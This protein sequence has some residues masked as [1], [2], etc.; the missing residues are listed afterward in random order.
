M[1][2]HGRHIEPAI[3]NVH[4]LTSDPKSATSK[5]PEQFFWGYFEGKRV[6]L[7]GTV[8][9]CNQKIKYC[10]LNFLYL[11]VNKQLIEPIE[12]AF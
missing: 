3:L 7:G 4:N 5:P 6:S 9:P 11:S 1:K 2:I 10:T 8:M 12:N